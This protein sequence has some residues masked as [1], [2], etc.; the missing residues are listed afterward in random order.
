MGTSTSFETT[1]P[2]AP[3]VAAPRVKYRYATVNGHRLFYREAGREDAPAIVLLHGFPS[4]SH[5]F[6]ELIPALADHYRVIAPDYLGFGYSDAP[7]IRSFSYTFDAL[8][9]LVEGL[10][11]SIGVS[12]CTLYMQDYGGPIGFRLATKNPKR[13]TGFV[14]QNA[15]AYLEG[16]G[17]P[18][19]N[20]FLPLWKART[21]ETEQVARTLLAAASTRS[22]YLEGA[23]TP[24]AVSPDAWMHDQAVLDR[25]GN[26]EIN[27]AL[28]VDYAKNVERYDEWH[29]YLKRHQPSTLIVWGENDPLFIKPGAE[30]YLRDLPNATIHYLNGGHFVLEEHAAVVA[31]RILQ[32]AGATTADSSEAVVLRFY[33]RLANGDI[34][35]LLSLFAESIEW[36]EAETFPYFGGTWTTPEQVLHG[37]LIPLSQ[38]W[39]NFAATPHKLIVQRGDV[40]SLGRYTGVYRA[41]GLSIDVAFAHHWRVAGGQIVGF[42]QHTDTAKVREALG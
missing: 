40:I 14:I 39:D 42:E 21:P 13:V 17:E 32:W 12:R 5:M 23:E 31:E 18:L 8:A 26:D 7:D 24:E 20:V 38:E 36:A 6:R 34:P 2:P 35:T 19:A 11:E 1:A 37:L 30:A 4:S 29:A 3:P 10:L 16:V 15:N 41:T 28:F 27:L 25:P 22:Q 33:D 9:G